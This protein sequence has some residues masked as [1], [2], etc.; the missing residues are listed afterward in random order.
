MK[1]IP[2]QILQSTTFVVEKS[3]FVKIN[4]DAIKKVAQRLKEEKWQLPQWDKNY[5]FF[6][7]SARTLAYFFILDSINFSFWSKKKDQKYRI[8]HQGKNIN[9]YNSLALSLKMAFSRHHPIEKNEYL[10][11]ITK[12]ELLKL[13]NGKGKLALLEKR[14]HI[15]HQNALIIKK[16]FNGEIKNVF[17]KAHNDAIALLDILIKY[18]PSFRDE[19]LY[20]RK[21]ILFYKRAQILINDLYAAFGGKGLGAFTNMDTLT[22]FADYKIPQ[23]LRHWDIFSYTPSLAKKIDAKIELKKNSPEELEIR[24]NTI[25]AVEYLKEELKVLGIDLQSR[26]IDWLLWKKASSEKGMKPYHRVRTVFY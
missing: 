5:H 17:D 10:I 26:E 18:F 11:K 3:E 25:W 20:K 21:N 22:A 14:L 16:H 19:A 4:E 15:L 1:N 8:R 23:I 13:L 6:D 24:A 9:G 7:N 2:N 12:S